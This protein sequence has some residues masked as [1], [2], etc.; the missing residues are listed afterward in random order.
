[1]TSSG[2]RTRNSLCPITSR[3]RASHNPNVTA[4]LEASRKR[5]NDMN[6]RLLIAPLAAALAALAIHTATSAAALAT[7]L[8]AFPPILARGCYPTGTLL[9]DAAGALYGSTGGCP[10]TQTNTVFR[11]TPPP[12]GQTKWTQSVLHSFTGGFDGATPNSNLVMDAGGA[13]YG[14]ATD[15]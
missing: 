5:R 7:T 15:G 2:P 10:I 14:T 4:S 8:Y 9:R 6:R 3:P 12:P 1:T 13:L 11:L